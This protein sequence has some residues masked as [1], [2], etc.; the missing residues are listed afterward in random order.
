[1]HEADLASI[2]RRSVFDLWPCPTCSTCTVA[3]Q[4]RQALIQ[5][6]DR[7]R[8]LWEQC[9]YSCFDKTV[10]K[11]EPGAADTLGL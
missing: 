5:E 4:D 2:R 10:L 8:D 1:M 3:A 6:L 9:R 7:V 11:R